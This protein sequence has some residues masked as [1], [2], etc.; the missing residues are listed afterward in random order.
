MKA[1]KK[2]NAF[3]FQPLHLGIILRLGLP[4][5]NN[6]TV[7]YFL[8]CLLVNSGSSL[9]TEQ[10]KLKAREIKYPVHRTVVNDIAYQVQ[11][12]I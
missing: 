3:F 2:Q 5:L 6:L 7:D 8:E 11:V 12:F 10:K 9:S 1:A 4:A